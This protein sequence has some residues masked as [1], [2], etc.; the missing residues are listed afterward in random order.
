MSTKPTSDE[1]EYLRGRKTERQA[2]L[3]SVNNHYESWLRN[4][5]GTRTPLQHVIT[6]LNMKTPLP[7]KSPYVDGRK[8]EREFI[9]KGVMDN[10]NEWM[11]PKPMSPSPLKQFTDWLNRN[12]L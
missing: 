4:D 10:H 5:D 6:M 3:N 12:T 2:I 11:A 9:L 8:F 7:P 1:A